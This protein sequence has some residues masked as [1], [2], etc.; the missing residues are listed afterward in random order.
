MQ[1]VNLFEALAKFP[2][3][4]KSNTHTMQVSTNSQKVHR[5]CN[6]HQAFHSD[7]WQP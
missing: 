6:F 3:L 4:E 5:T 7:M 1:Q 2:Q